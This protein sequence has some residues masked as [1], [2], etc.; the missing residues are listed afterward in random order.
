MSSLTTFRQLWISVKKHDESGPAIVHRDASELNVRDSLGALQ[1]LWISQKNPPEAS[2]QRSCAA[3]L[4][5]KMRAPWPF[6]C[7]FEHCP[8]STCSR[9]S[10]EALSVLNALWLRFRFPIWSLFLPSVTQGRD[11]DINAFS[12]R[13]AAALSTPLDVAASPLPAVAAPVRLDCRDL[14]HSALVSGHL[15]QVRAARHRSFL[16]CGLSCSPTIHCVWRSRSRGSLRSRRMRGWRPPDSGAAKY[17]RRGYL[18]LPPAT[19]LS[20]LPPLASKVQNSVMDWAA[21]S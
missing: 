16:D 10:L 14:L 15:C 13:G 21:L 19:R 7:S 8:R 20:P 3:R 4:E 12:R 9:C 11:C 2:H 17:W 5:F 18:P 1:K 6:S